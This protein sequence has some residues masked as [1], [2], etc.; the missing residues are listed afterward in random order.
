VDPL[1]EAALI[2]GGASL[3]SIA[4]T[5]VVAV[6]GFR[7][8]SR[9]SRQTSADAAEGGLRGRL[10]EKQADLYVE[11]IKAVEERRS[12][13]RYRLRLVS[14]GAP[15]RSYAESAHWDELFPRLIAYAAPPIHDVLNAATEANSHVRDLYEEYAAMTGPNREAAVERIRTAVEQAEAKDQELF[16]MIR[17]DLRKRPGEARAMTDAPGAWEEPS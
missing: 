7:S 15:F 2:A 13:R 17:A 9:V 8:T 3:I 6:S 14:T 12:E 11:I 10:W 1:V 5:V 4:G 16:K